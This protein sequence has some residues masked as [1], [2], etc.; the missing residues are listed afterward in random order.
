MT[1][2]TERD[3][4]LRN[5]T[6]APED[7]KTQDTGGNCSPLE[8]APSTRYWILAG[9]WVATFL[10]V[11]LPAISCLLLGLMALSTERR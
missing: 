8:V 10:S 2:P 4:L 5:E 9:V 11:C 3:P 1:T 6:S 7:G